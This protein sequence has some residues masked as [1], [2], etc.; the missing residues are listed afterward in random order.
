M[1]VTGSP[2]SAADPAG[3]LVAGTAPSAALGGT[4]SFTTYLPPGYDTATE[5]YPTLYLLHGRGDTQKAWTQVSGDLDAMIAD[6]SVPPLVVVMP[7]APWSG[8]GS[9]YVD[10]QYTGTAPAAGGPGKAVETAL[11][12]DLVTYVDATYRTVDDRSARAVGGYSMGGAGAL[13][14]ALAHQDVFSAAIVLSPA[15]YVPSPPADSSTR[16]YGAYG[17]GTALFDQA[18]YDALNYPAALAAVDPALPVHLFIAVGDDEYANPAPADARHDLDLESAQLYNA[19]RRVPGITAELRVMNGG[20]DWTVWRP[21]F[22]EGLTDLASY[23]RTTAPDPLAGATF[24]S[25]GDDRAGGVVASPD[26]SVVVAVN[27]AAA[28]PGVARVG[29]MDAVL[30]ARSAAGDPLWTHVLGTTANDRAYGLVPGAAGAVLTAGYT[31]GNLD[32]THPSGASDDVFVAAVD[33]TGHES[34]VK[35]L[36]DP[37]KADRVYATASDGAG[38]IY[39]AGYTSG[40]FAGTPSAGDKDAVL[41][42]FDGAGN[43]LWADQIGSP[44]EDKAL[45]ITRAA[46]GGA[47]VAGIAGGAM[48]GTTGL[49]GNDGWVARYS[50]AGARQWVTAV[51]TSATDEI[52][53]LVTTSDGV[54]VVGDTEGALGGAAARGD[55]DAFVASVAADGTLGWS[56]QLGTTG[57]DRAVAVV[58]DPSGRLLVVGHTA[59]RMAGGVGGVDLFRV[60]VTPGGTPGPVTQFGTVER[61]GM[62]DYDSNLF[63]A[64]DGATTAWLSALTYGAADGDVNAGAGDVLLTSVP[65][66]TAAPVV[67]PGVTDPGSAAIVPPDSDGGTPAAQSTPVVR[68]GFLS[69]TG[70]DPLRIAVLAG[71]FLLLGTGAVGMRRRARSGAPT[72]LG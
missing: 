63:L 5:S 42:R 3:T 14:Y 36:G 49:G 43:L 34:W 53:G 2:A 47:Y 39:V 57:D 40:S 72:L 18:R 60:A 65:F 38:G 24:G 33:S 58:A 37:A 45:A 1:T 25:V 50:P 32:G 4:I 10:S 41:A 46:D 9:W 23:L 64:Y 56:T 30:Q 52:L 13:R 55:K 54:A 48:P 35:Q 51:G 12:H 31:R 22:R 8:G 15:V 71:S 11:T 29:G 62:D 27:A 19:A 59:G 67:T 20:H 61:D 16:D 69:S 66:G 6:G 26:G 17:V 70:F 7:D 28:L 21:G 44:G 68:H